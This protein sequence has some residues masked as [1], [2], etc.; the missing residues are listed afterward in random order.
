MEGKESEMAKQAK[1][2]GGINSNKLVHKPVIGGKAPVGRNPGA[3]GQYGTSIGDHSTEHSGGLPNALVPEFTA[4]RT[5]QTQGNENS[6]KITKMG[7]GRTVYPRGPNGIH[8]PVNPGA[9]I[10][11]RDPFEGLLNKRGQ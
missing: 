8:G 4:A 11:R 10:P 1:A 7:Q 2:G 3:V 5:N 6:P 9:P